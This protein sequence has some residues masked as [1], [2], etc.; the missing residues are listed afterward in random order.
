VLT[1]R[2]TFMAGEAKHASRPGQHGS[3]GIAFG[4]LAR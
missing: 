4:T 1:S 2:R 3:L